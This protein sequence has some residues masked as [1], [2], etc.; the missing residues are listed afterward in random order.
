MAAEA[1]KIGMLV[2]LFGISAP[3]NDRIINGGVSPF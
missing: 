2:L 1:R 3:N